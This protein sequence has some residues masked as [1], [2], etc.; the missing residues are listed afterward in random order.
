MAP[1]NWLFNHLNDKMRSRKMRPRGVLIDEKDAIMIT[2][3]LAMQ[4]CKLSIGL[5][6]STTKYEG[7]KLIQTMATHFQKGISKTTNGISSSVNIW[8]WTFDKW[9]DL[10]FTKHRGW[11][12][13]PMIYYTTTCNHCI[14]NSITIKILYG[15]HMKQG[16]EHENNKKTR[17]LTRRISK[18]IYNIVPKFQELL[19]ITL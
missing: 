19:T 1:L 9:K 8:K 6:L 17:V 18:A 15:I 11:H 14:F 13:I 7:C 2:W 4:E 16:F 3:T 10:E 12:P 5:Q